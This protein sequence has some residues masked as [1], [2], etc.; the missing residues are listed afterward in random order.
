MSTPA[1]GTA[2]LAAFRLNSRQNEP[3]AISWPDAQPKLNSY[4]KIALLKHSLKNNHEFEDDADVLDG[5]SGPS[6]HDKIAVMPGGALDI[7][8]GFLGLDQLIAAALG[9]EKVRGAALESPDFGISGLGTTLTGTTAA[10]TT[11]T[12]L[13]ASSGVF[14]SD[15]IIGDWVR[16]QELSTTP[17]LF[18]QVRKIVGRTST[19]QI[20][21]APTWN[22]SGG[23]DP[24]A[25]KTFAV[26]REFLHTYE[27][28]KH[29]HGENFKDIMAGQWGTAIGTNAFLTRHG[30]L[31]TWNGWKYEEWQFAFI[32]KLTFKLD[33]KNGL[34]VSAECVP[35]FH[36][37]TNSNSQ[38]K[39]SWR[40]VNG[41]QAVPASGSSFM[42]YERVQFPDAVFRL[43]AFSTGT[44]LSASHNV[45]ISEIEIT[46]ENPLDDASQ[47]T[48]SGLYREEPTRSEK[49]K[50]YGSF[51]LSRHKEN[52]RVTQFLNESNLM[53]SL[54]FTGSPITTGTVRNNELKI[55]LRR[56]R[57]ETP[58]TSIPGVG[59]V[60]EKHSFVC[61]N[62]DNVTGNPAGMPTPTVGDGIENGPVIIQTRNQFPF[63]MFMA[64]NHENL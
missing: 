54:T 23:S 38:T 61:L 5:N 21:V 13:V 60:P 25:G 16:I 63:N 34:L 59:V 7:K 49:R 29:M 56:L 15:A 47:T 58:D 55:W 41:T 3:Y 10:G 62:C 48:S 12:A 51:T 11:A 31:V 28:S 20:T 26:A 6:Q 33:A 42:V 9:F 36:D 50:V 35:A 17:N 44:A 39:D 18:D 1:Q 37:L 45:G 57:L 43:A 30:T 64:Q 22:A 40:Y 14:T 53:A 2:T 52:T 32:K 19:T 8:A 4:D 27:C 24:G 46:I